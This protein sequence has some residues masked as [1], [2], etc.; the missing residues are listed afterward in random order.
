MNGT[1]IGKYALVVALSATLLACAGSAKPQPQAPPGTDATE[2]DSADAPQFERRSVVQRLL[3][4]A[5]AAF[6]RGRYTLPAE[7]N[8]FDKYQA[9]LLL[10]P[11]NKAAQAGLD[12]VLLAY[13]DHVRSVMAAGQLTRAQELV[14]RAGAY[15][16]AAPLLQE[17]NAEIKQA[18]SALNAKTHEAAQAD[19]V[20]G[21]KVLLPEHDLSQ[22]SDSI[23]EMLTALAQRVRESGESVMILARSDREGRW[24]YKQMQESVAGYRI[25]GDI[26]INRVPAV[27]LMAPL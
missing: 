2:S 20:D 16:A 12:A 23:K 4:Q 5:D 7:D 19:T 1:G 15:F 13:V 14:T 6:E 24:I 26:R 11:G 10:D 3:E 8:A 18:R 17:L 9:V 27:V 22:R 25:R 21:E